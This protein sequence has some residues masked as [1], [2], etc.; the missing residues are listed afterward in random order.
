MYGIDKRIQFH[1]H[2]DSANFSRTSKT[3]SLGVTANG[4]EEKTIRCRFL[5]LCSGYYD[6]DNPLQ[7]QIPGIETF[8]GQLA[9]PQFW[10]QDMDY[11]DK[12]VVI[13]GS[14]ATAYT[15]PEPGQESDP[16]D[17]TPALAK[18]CPGTAW[19]RRPRESHS[20]ADMVVK[21]ARAKVDPLEVAVHPVPA[22]TLLLHLSKCSS[23]DVAEEYPSSVAAD[24]TT[25]SSLQSK[26]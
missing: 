23:Q 6:Y 11:T 12:N 17:D 2:I 21:T 13:V 8:E 25:R 19:R 5:L 26:L 9:H 7:A 15:A 3:W 24:G 18:L 14:G 10:P 22:H 1:H 4:T 20:E 16:C